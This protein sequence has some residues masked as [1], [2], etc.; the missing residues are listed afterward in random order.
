MRPS[1]RELAVLVLASLAVLAGPAVGAAQDVGTVS[2]QLTPLCSTLTVA[3][4]GTPP[5]FQVAGY[6]DSCGGETLYPAFGT[7]VGDVSG[8]MRMGL[9]VVLPSAVTTSLHLTIDPASGT[10]SWT[11]PF[12][13]SGALVPVAFVPAAPPAGS[14]R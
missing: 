5:I 9:T 3:V 12:G 1:P 13:Q 2:W 7:A 10:G 8:T 6:V 4:T 11:E 14:A